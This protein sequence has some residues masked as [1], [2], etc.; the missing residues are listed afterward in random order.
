MT[1]ATIVPDGVRDTLKTIL[2]SV[3]EE[4]LGQRLDR[5]ADAREI[6]QDP[7]IDNAERG[8]QVHELFEGVVR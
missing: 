4:A 7:T 8:R 2:G 3:L 5:Y 1:T 6:A